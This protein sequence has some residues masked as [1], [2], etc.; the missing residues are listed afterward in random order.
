MSI[1]AF[2]LELRAMK[3]SEA[4]PLLIKCEYSLH[5]S[6]EGHIHIIYQN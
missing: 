4:C 6:E 1:H 3:K 2:F 5:S